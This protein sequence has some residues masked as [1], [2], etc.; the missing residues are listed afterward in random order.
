M[1]LILSDSHTIRVMLTDLSDQFHGLVQVKR[2]S[3]A[4]ALELR[5]SCTNPSNYSFQGREPAGRWLFWSCVPGT[6]QGS[7]GG[8]EGVHADWRHQPSQTTQ[9]GGQTRLQIGSVPSQWLHIDGLVQERRNSSALAM[10]LRLYCTNPSTCDMA[11]QITCSQ[12]DYLFN[13]SIRLT[14]L[15]KASK[16]FIAAPSWEESTGDRWIPLT[17]DQSCGAF[18]FS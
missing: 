6:L 9:A 17:K 4:S 16:F 5:L 2:N 1:R 10:E 13:N 12:L 3:T 11:S 8:G 18:I 7:D 15:Q 14:L